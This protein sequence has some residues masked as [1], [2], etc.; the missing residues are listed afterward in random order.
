MVRRSM[1][2]T[3]RRTKRVSPVGGR[4]AAR[5]EYVTLS[6]HTRDLASALSF[7]PSGVFMRFKTLAMA[8]A[9]AATLS[10]SALAQTEIQWWHSMTAVNNEWVNDLARQFNESQK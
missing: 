10:T 7:P 8:S 1:H 2:C 3:P 9:L 5:Q 4:R 6:C